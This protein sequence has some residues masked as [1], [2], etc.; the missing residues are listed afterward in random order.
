MQT[1][2]VLI[3]DTKLKF[4]EHLEDKTNACN[5]INGSMKNLSLILPRT[6]L[7]TIYKAFVRLHL[8]Y[9]DIIYDKPA[10]ESFKDWVEKFQYNAAL[11]ITIS[12]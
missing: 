8:D 10:N 6:G 12:N 11:V 4:N 1:A 7:L 9:A 2:V 3:P 5:R